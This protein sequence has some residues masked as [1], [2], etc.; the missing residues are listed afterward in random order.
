MVLAVTL[1]SEVTMI[2]PLHIF[3]AKARILEGV[4]CRR[5]LCDYV[6]NHWYELDKIEK[7][8]LFS[9][10]IKKNI[11]MNMCIYLGMDT[12]YKCADIFRM[13]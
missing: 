2:I 5:M 12:V 8:K 9:A 13:F 6:V 1:I 4:P 7:K 10:E 3:P 11:V